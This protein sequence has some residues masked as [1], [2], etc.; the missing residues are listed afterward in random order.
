MLL[1]A[2]AL[3]LQAETSP[4]DADR[5]TDALAT[6]DLVSRAEINHQQRRRVMTLIREGDCEGAHGAVY[7]MGDAEMF[8]LV[9]SQCPVA[10]SHLQRWTMLTVPTNRGTTCPS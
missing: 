2:L 7:V 3:A 6:S 9:E 4:A 5:V 10:I 8:D 1:I